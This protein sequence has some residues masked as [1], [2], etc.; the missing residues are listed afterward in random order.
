MVVARCR[1]LF[2]ELLIRDQALAI[3]RLQARSPA[4]LLRSALDTE[5]HVLVTT[6]CSIAFASAKTPGP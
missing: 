3:F 2:A 1:P 6:A 4:V 5:L